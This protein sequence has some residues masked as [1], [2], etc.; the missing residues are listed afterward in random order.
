MLAQVLI[1]SKGGYSAEQRGEL[2]CTAARSEGLSIPF[3][4]EPHCW[5]WASV[6]G[7]GQS[8]CC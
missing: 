1:A 6:L 5:G 2:P 4:E 8:A 7:P 3:R